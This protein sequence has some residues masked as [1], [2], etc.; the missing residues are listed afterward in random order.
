MNKQTPEQMWDRQQMLPTDVDYSLWKK[1]RETLPDLSTL[2]PGCIF[3]VDV[4]KKAYDYASARFADIW[5]YNPSFIKGIQ[6]HKCYIED[7][8]HPDDRVW[9][10]DVQIMHSEFIYSL[11]QENRNDYSTI[12][13]FRLLNPKQQYI[14]VTSRQQV[15]MKDKAG[16]AW[17]IMGIMDIS[18][19][20]NPLQH[21]RFTIQN[22]KTGEIHSP[23]QSSGQQLTPREME[24][25]SLVNQG[26]LSKEIAA[27]LGISIH[28]V[29]NHR[30]RILLKLNAGNSM[31]AVNRVRGLY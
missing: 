15:L 29:N 28:T 7:R 24:I 3:T 23:L 25:L 12:Y 26:L 14:Y 8:I 20:Q 19:D 16:K 2:T 1:K 9:M 21:T 10:E 31:E 5:G 18:P 6:N 22:I 4:Y 27:I 11:P 17:I 13:Q 30:K